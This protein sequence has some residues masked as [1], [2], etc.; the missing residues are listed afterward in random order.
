M[1]VALVSPYALDVPGGVQAHVV[2]LA[3][4]LRALGDEVTIVAPGDGDHLGVGAARAVSFNGSKAPIAVSPG[5]ARAT[6]RA[7]RELRP[8]VVHVHEPLVPAVGL[9]AATTDVAPVVAT[10]HAWSDRARLYRTGRTI[11]RRVVRHVGTWVAVSDAAAG[12]HGRG[13]GVPARAF[14]VVPNGVDVARFSDGTPFADIADD[15]RPSLLFVGR[16]EPRKGLEPLVR[17]F[18]RLK[19]TRPDL[20][21][22][23]VGDGPERA[24]CQALLPGALR[25]D[26]VFLGRVDHDDLPRYY[27]SCDLY[28]SPALGG[29]SF[30]IVLLEAMAAGAPIVASDLPG[31]RSVAR[32][33]V[34]GRL[35]PPGDPAALADAIGALLD[36]PA[37]RAAMAGEG[38]RT[39][40][41]YDWPVVAQ[42]V[43]TLYLEAIA[44]S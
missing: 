20:R 26:V 10:F 14:S 15:P 42:R 35:V 23:V 8:D 25:T 9:A 5:A 31:Y 34:Q 2:D 17:A 19:S 30:G 33:G 6:R 21:L 32:D 38:R 11:A 37:L 43:R 27:R 12:Y 28:V 41:D 40:A 3:S 36:N 7:L 24:R 29:E 44:T 4:A 18:T 13:L 1:R 22:Y 39:V 16:L